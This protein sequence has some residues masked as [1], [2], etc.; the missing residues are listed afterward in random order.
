MTD[1]IK[2]THPIQETDKKLAEVS[3]RT[4]TRKASFYLY[5]SED[6]KYLCVKQWSNTQIEEN[7]ISIYDSLFDVIR[8]FGTGDLATQLYKQA[9]IDHD[10]FLVGARRSD[11]LI[12]KLLAYTQGALGE[13]YD[14]EYML[15]RDESG[16]YRCLKRNNKAPNDPRMGWCQSAHYCD[17]IKEA[18]EFFGGDP[19]ALRIKEQLTHLILI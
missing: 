17:K 9:R 12:G 6:G 2:I 1:Q 11:Q 4:D 18:I 15:Y 14:V 19:L 7:A 3:E 16:R 5:Q 10:L 13:N 8:F